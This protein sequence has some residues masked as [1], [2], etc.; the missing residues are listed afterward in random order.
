MKEK[1]TYPLFPLEVFAFPGEAFKLH[2]F[3]EKYKQLVHDALEANKLFAI[4]YVLNGEKQDYGCLVRVMDIEREDQN[5]EMD[6]R[7]EVKEVIRCKT[8]SR[9]PQKLYSEGNVEYV[10][11]PNHKAGP[12]LVYLFSKFMSL[13]DR[14][15][16]HAFNL[17]SLSLFE[18]AALVHIPSNQKF[19]LVDDE[20]P[21]HFERNLTNFLQLQVQIETLTK[22][23]GPKFVLN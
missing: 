7:V 21:D 13:S 5:G 22:Q 6:I 4:P 2:I 20:L 12:R 19:S 16:S 9:S 8:Q 18:I 17:S 3:E 10:T 23:M 14:Q 15:K 1:H 11:Y